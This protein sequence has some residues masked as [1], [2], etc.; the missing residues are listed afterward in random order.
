MLHCQHKIPLLLFIGRARINNFMSKFDWD[1]AK[2][3]EHFRQQT[4]YTA[5]PRGAHRHTPKASEKQ[6]IFVQ[7]LLRRHG[8][9]EWSEP[10]LEGMTMAQADRLI[11]S[12]L[13][14][15]K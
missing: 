12:L 14:L 3:T 4:S 7:S 1:K 2:R 13:P 8:K 9:R 10:E 11:S 6:K 15:A 5:A